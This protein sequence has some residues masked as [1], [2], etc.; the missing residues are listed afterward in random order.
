MI[1]ARL[2]KPATIMAVLF[3]Q[4]RVRSIERYLP[5]LKHTRNACPETRPLLLALCYISWT[6]VAP[7][8]LGVRG[9]RRLVGVMPLSRDMY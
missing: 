6:R 4:A 7:N 2:R 9:Q 8:S 1:G 3:C 5:V